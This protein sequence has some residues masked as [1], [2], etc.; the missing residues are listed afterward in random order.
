LDALDRQLSAIS[1]FQMFEPGIENLLDS[2]QRLHLGLKPCVHLCA[3]AIY[4]CIRLCTQAVDL[5]GVDQN[6]Q[7][8]GYGWYSDCERLKCVG[9]HL[10]L[11][12][13]PDERGERSLRS[14]SGGFIQPHRIHI[15]ARDGQTYSRAAG[16]YQAH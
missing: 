14:E 11:E 12:S 1:F 10:Y 8:D 9:F 13:F 15:R 16:L 6:A 3:K 5:A 7:Q 2:Q 4:F